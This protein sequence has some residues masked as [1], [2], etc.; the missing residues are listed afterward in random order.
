MFRF[1]GI[2]LGLNRGYAQNF[3]AESFCVQLA[4]HKPSILAPIAEVLK[5][6][7][8]PSGRGLGA[9]GPGNGLD[10]VDVNC[11]CPI[12]LVFKSGSGSAR[13]S[14]KQRNSLLLYI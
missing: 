11:G 13:K 9:L 12:D 10:F 7:L 14:F 6:E 2:R 8:G 1:A 3:F 4:G 5:T